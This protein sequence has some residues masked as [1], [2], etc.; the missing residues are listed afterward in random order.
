MVDAS[1]G[2]VAKA[3]LLSTE[4]GGTESDASGEYSLCLPE[5]DSQVRVEAAGYG[6]VALPFRLFGEFHYDVVLVPE[7]VLVGQVVANDGQAVADARVIATPDDVDGVHHVATG[8]ATADR[9]GRFQIA[10]LAPGRFRINASAEGLAMRTPKV[11]VA[12]PATSSRELRLALEGVAQVHGRVLMAGRPVTGARI[13]VLRE[14]APSGAA[15]FSQPD[16]SFVLSG[17]PF[18]INELATPPYELRSPRSLAIDRSV[19]D[20]VVLDVSA[21]ATLRGHVT[22]KGKPVAGAEVQCARSPIHAR[23]D[24][25]GAYVLEGLPPGDHLI[26]AWGGEDLAYTADKPEI[27]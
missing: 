24:L 3:R 13:T 20:D 25:S 14:G 27:R 22:R 10:G 26:S 19:V 8:W 4:R 7:A 16:G 5:S 23:T 1:G 6:T 2:G 21:L 11:A 18:G 17:I 15:S 12:W 9:D